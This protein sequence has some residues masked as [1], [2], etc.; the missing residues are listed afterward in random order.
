MLHATWMSPE[1][2]SSCSGEGS[3]NEFLSMYLAGILPAIG[4]AGGMI[5]IFIY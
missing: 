4:T 3:E 2:R 5:A 1:D